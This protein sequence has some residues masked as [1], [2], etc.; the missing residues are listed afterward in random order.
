MLEAI[1]LLSGGFA[2]EVCGYQT[3][4]AVADFV[5]Q[6]FLDWLEALFAEL[7]NG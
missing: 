5:W 3:D 7:F 1:G 2:A 4:L 6:G